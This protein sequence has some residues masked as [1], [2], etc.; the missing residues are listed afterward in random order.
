M[1]STK[2][3]LPKHWTIKVSK[4]HN[5]E[6]YFNQKTK[7][8]S[9][10]PPDNTNQDELAEYIKNFKNNQYKPVINEGKIR[11]NHL[12][13][14]NI[15]SRKPKSWKNPDITLSRDDAIIIL[16]KHLNKILQDNVEFSELAKEESDCSS[17]QKGGD[18]GYFS[19]GQMQPSFEQAA[20]NLHV[21]EISDIIESDSGVHIIERTG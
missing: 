4:T 3:G 1:V 13:I 16:K 5:K 14:K 9:W 12:L 17:H 7:E 2:T 10:T 19:K 21:G 8:S 20:F 11:V 18:L 6:Y 15:T